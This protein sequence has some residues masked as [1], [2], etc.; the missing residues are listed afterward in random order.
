[1]KR[2][3]ISTTCFFALTVAAHAQQ[4]AAVA[5]DPDVAGK[6]LD[7]DEIVVSAT[8]TPTQIYKVGSSITVLTDNAIRESQTPVVSDLLAQ[9]PG[10][11][12]SRNGGVGGT[13]A[14]R[15]RGAETDQ[16]VVVIDGV[17]LNDPASTG[18]GY[19]FAN[20][21]T[22]DIERMEV[23]RGAQ[24]TL[25]G[26]QA[27]GGVVNVLTATP[28]K[29]FEVSA[30]AEGGSHGT[31]SASA[32]IGGVRDKLTWRAA[33][34]TYTTDGISAYVNGTEPD[35]Y[36]NIGASGRL[37]Y[38]IADDLSVDLRGVYSR[39]RNKFD[40]FPPPSFAFN[41][42]REF[43]TT[44]EFVGYAGVNFAVLEGALKNRVAYAY[45][46]TDRDLFNPD[47]A[48]TTRTYDSAGWNKRFEYQG[49][50]SVA[51]GW[52]VVFGAEHETSSFRTASPTATAPNPVPAAASVTLD[53]GY[54]Q[55]QAT[56]L[57]GLIFTGGLRYDSHG[58]FGSRALGQAAVAWSFNDGNTILRTSFGQGFKA[59]TLYQLYSIYGNTTLNPEKADSF[60][61]GIEQHLFDGA[62]VLNATGFYRKTRNQIDFVSCPSTNVLCVIGKPG[63]Y[64]NISS[65]RAKGMELAGAGKIGDLSIQ[66]NYT[67][68]DVTN[69]SVGTANF[70]KRLA[71]RPRDAANLWVTYTWP[72]HVSTGFTVRYEGAVFDDAANRNVLASH[73]LLDLRAAYEF[74]DG[75]EVYGRVENLTDKIYQT[76]RNYG[77]PRRSVFGGVRAK[78]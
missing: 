49:S 74:M 53:S 25:W 1:M 76:T 70:G 36:R 73:T 39:G 57:E 43:G 13:T 29:P 19:N 33:A 48:V 8:R 66:A 9:T 46:D 61:G 7:V 10:V 77:S 67:L 31:G 14:L 2:V 58:T 5:P 68:T 35:G 56:L 42:T 69:Q 38:E 4:Q 52:D 6:G 40:G 28:Q 3:L 27:I 12:F 16:T 22:G 60:D 30:A 26:S 41:D 78:F 24:S 63:V 15:I 18:G 11:S 47:Q 54:G 51:Q 20:L 64:D 44:K 21:L 45:T 37:R 65:T 17:K 23:L 50:A 62:L 59:P 55:V 32:A 75:L 71:R 34:S 72:M